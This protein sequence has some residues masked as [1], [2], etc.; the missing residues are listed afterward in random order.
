ME[1]IWWTVFVVSVCLLL[2][3]WFRRRPDIRF[4]G[5]AWLHLV[6]SAV[7][8]Y[9]INGTGLFGDFYIPINGATVLAIAVLGLPGLGLIAALK[10]TLV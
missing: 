8:L 2:L 9:L 1:R 10:W 4:F 6:V 7:L 3:V 5:F